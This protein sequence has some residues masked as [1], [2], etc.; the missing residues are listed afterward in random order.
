MK[1][2]LS[3]CS[4][5]FSFLFLLQPQVTDGFQLIKCTVILPLSPIT[6]PTSITII[7]LQCIGVGNEDRLR[8]VRIRLLP[9]PGLLGFNVQL[10][11]LK[12]GKTQNPRAQKYSLLS[13]N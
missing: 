6:N 10:A 9:H 13:P 2:K 5:S 11:K 12:V 3:H 1:I 4:K 8:R 7:F